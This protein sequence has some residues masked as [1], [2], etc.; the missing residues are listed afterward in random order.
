[1]NPTI[2]ASPV[3]NAIIERVKE[4][5]VRQADALTNTKKRKELSLAKDFANLKYK[6]LHEQ[7]VRD[8]TSEE[9][10]NEKRVPPPVITSPI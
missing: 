3:F 7:G 1:M 5:A 9:S 10:K 6:N 8:I 2:F 4:N